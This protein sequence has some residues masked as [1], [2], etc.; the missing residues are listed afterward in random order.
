MFEK[1]ASLVFTLQFSVVLVF[2]RPNHHSSHLA[3]IVG[4]D[5]LVYSIWRVLQRATELRVRDTSNENIIVK[6][7]ILLVGSNGIQQPA[8]LQH[9][10]Q[11]EQN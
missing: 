3:I 9:H 5:T 2:S 6:S 1:H 4:I 10:N 11:R 8:Q 7:K